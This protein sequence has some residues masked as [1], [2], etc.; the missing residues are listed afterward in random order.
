[1]LS[2]RVCLFLGL[3]FTLKLIVCA[4]QTSPPDVKFQISRYGHVTQFQINSL[5]NPIGSSDEISLFLHSLLS[6]FYTQ[7]IYIEISVL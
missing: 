3:S 1:M 7:K 5:T 6:M 4:I 2:L